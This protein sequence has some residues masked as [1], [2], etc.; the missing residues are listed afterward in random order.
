M[1]EF[2]KVTAIYNCPVWCLGLLT[3]DDTGRNTLLRVTFGLVIL[4]I[5]NTI[6]LFI[7]E[8]YIII[9]CDY[10]SQTGSG[11]MTQVCIFANSHHTNKICRQVRLRPDC[12]ERNL[13]FFPLTYVQVI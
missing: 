13:A 9:M 4:R 12:T 10:Q 1:H 7:E 2:L 6:E 11:E 8:L 5:K 3:A